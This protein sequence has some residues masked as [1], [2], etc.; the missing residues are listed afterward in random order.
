[1]E[2]RITTRSVRRVLTI[3]LDM[4][5]P[6]F[7]WPPKVSKMDSHIRHAFEN[8][9][10]GFAIFIASSP[11]QWRHNGH[12][13]VSNHQPY[14]CLLSRLFRHRLKQ[15]SKLR[16]TGLC[17]GNSPETGEF[18][19]QRASYAEKVSIWWRHHALSFNTLIG[20]GCVACVNVYMIISK[21]QFG[22]V[23]MVAIAWTTISTP[24]LE[25]KPNATHV[26]RTTLD[27]KYGGLN[28]K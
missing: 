20:V 21:I 27:F 25:V 4:L 5:P 2:N 19:A 24:C 22:N 18:P 6:K 11:L 16:V 23:A 26:K 15:T 10:K 17:A 9:F 14:D 3:K 7:L 1:M 8:V 28:I 12:D 13:S